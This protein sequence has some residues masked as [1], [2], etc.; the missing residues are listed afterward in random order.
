MIYAHATRGEYGDPVSI[1]A[2][3]YYY[4]DYKGRVLMPDDIF[5]LKDTQFSTTDQLNGL[6]RVYLY[7]LSFRAG[8]SIQA[9]QSAISNAGLKPPQLLN[10]PEQ[11]D[12]ESLKNVKS[13]VSKFFSGGQ[14]A[15][16]GNVFNFGTRF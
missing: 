3:G 7:E 13:V 12:K 16:S 15:Q 8:Y 14:S 5:H 10:Y 6:S 11:V 4:R 2:G 1:Q 9:V